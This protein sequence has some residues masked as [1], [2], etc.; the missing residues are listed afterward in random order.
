MKKIFK[1]GSIILGT[2]LFLFGTAFFI[3]LSGMTEPINAVLAVVFIL[4]PLS[5]YSFYK[6]K[7]LRGCY[8]IVLT[9]FLILV[10]DVFTKVNIRTYGAEGAAMSLEERLNIIMAEAELSD[11]EKKVRRYNN[12]KQYEISKLSSYEIVERKG[13][14]LEDYYYIFH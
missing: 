6:K 12:E 8:V 13:K 11:Q 9:I 1:Y 10:I 3:A 4:I 5:I 7:K 14:T 2:I